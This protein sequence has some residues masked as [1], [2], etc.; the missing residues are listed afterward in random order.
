[1]Y[2]PSFKIERSDLYNNP[3]I[4]K[5]VKLL[6]ESS[7]FIVKNINLFEK[8]EFGLVEDKEGVIKFDGDNTEESIVIKN[9]FLIATINSDLLCD[10]QIPTISAFVV[11]K[12]NWIKH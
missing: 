6:N 3:S 2:L 11:H 4:F 10:L 8:I 7:E 9:D 1:M 5:G 12:E